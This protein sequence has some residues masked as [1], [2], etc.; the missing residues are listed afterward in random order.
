MP[1][2]SETEVSATCCR[3]QR[4]QGSRLAHQQTNHAGNDGFVIPRSI[5]RHNKWKRIAPNPRLLQKSASPQSFHTGWA[6][7]DPN[8]QEDSEYA[9]H[10]YKQTKVAE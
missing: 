9:E 6:G 3:I 2:T 10:H 4:L 5:G 8:D 7:Q 1:L